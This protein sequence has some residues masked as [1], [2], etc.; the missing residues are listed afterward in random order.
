MRAA[1]CYEYGKPLV[2]E[3]VNIDPPR[4]GEVKCKLVATAIC[5][6]DIRQIRESNTGNPLPTAP[7]VSG[8]ECAGYV[9]EVGEGVESVKPGDPA[10]VSHIAYCGKCFYCRTGRPHLCNF[11]FLLDKESRLSRKD[12]QRLMPVI[13]ISGFAEEV[14]VD[15][16][17]V[18]KIPADMPMDAASLLSCGVIT[19]FGAV[20]NRTKAEPNSSIVVIGTG[21]VGLNAIQGARFVGA[22]PII[23][24]D[25]VDSKLEAAKFFGAT[26]TINSK[27]VDP[28]EAVKKLTQGR[29][30]DYIYVA[31]GSNPAVVQAFWMSGPRGTTV[32]IGLP[33]K[34][35]AILSLPIHAF[36][37][38]ER[39]IMG[40]YMGSTNLSVDIPN[41]VSL[42]QS[43]RLK[44]NELITKR[45]S[46]DQINEALESSE[47]T[48]A[49][50]NV[51]MF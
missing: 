18:V 28:V 11:E 3:D 40:G 14:I 21:G 39:V 33:S 16:S 42:Y 25:V 35:E 9:A 8:H 29:G 45:Y 20:V 50:R 13:G 12:G 1:V 48:D 37:K 6:S 5:H 7:F 46:L 51:I 36:I 34:S 49:L 17:Q 24:V 38:D 31:V 41:L 23:A 44:L 10:V 15:E 22:N 27:K 43:G 4:K 30:A 26:H 19:G 32:L 2:V 47:K